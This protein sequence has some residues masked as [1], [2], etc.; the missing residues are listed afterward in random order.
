MNSTGTDLVFLLDRSGS[1][2]HAGFETE[3]TFVDNFL[4]YFEVMPN[5]TRVAIVSFSD[6]VGELST[7]SAS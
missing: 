7:F 2:G 6:K 5:A 3:L 1:V 4:N